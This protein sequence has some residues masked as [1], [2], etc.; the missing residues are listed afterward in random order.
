MDKFNNIRKNQVIQDNA[1]SKYRSNSNMS[2]KMGD[3]L[4]PLRAQQ[5]RKSSSDCRSTAEMEGLKLKTK[6]P[7]SIRFKDEETRYKS[8]A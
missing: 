1:S 8:R 6:G 7:K 3:E 5:T 2:L 4:N